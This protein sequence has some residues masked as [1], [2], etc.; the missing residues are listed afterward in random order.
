MDH[1][2]DLF[3]EHLLYNRNS[4]EN[5]IDAYSRDINEWF[6]YLEEKNLKWDALNYKD[7]YGFLVYT[8]QEKEISNRTQA[9]KAASIRSFYRFC[10]NQKIIDKDLLK[11]WKAPKY[12]RG[13]PKPIRPIELEKIL[14]D[15]SS[16]D[17]MIQKRDIALWELMYSAGIRISEV[18]SLNINDVFDKAEGTDG[19]IYDAIKVMG[20]GSKER[21][22][23]IGSKSAQAIK[24]YLVIREQLLEKLNLEDSEDALFLNMRGK[25]L[26]RRGANYVL[27]KRKKALGIHSNISAHSFRHSFAT[28]LLNE[29]AGIREVQ[30]MLGHSN[31]STTQNYTYVA[32]D[33]LI[34]V[35][36]NNHPHAK[37]N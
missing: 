17:N 20:K 30:E 26:S 11:G 22:V 23:F 24:E 19:M 13:L 10:F 33:R 32:K 18:L 5:T 3:I 4:S 9:R 2:L 14:E 29:G 12:K 16:Q 27:Q 15:D 35:F 28:D 31:V 7:I 37:K 1:L 21:V 6:N 25:R 8:H 34:E 36:R